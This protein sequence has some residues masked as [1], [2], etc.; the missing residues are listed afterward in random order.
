MTS[1]RVA[2]TPWG[3]GAIAGLSGVPRAAA[4]AP[5]AEAEDAEGVAGA[6]FAV[7]SSPRGSKASLAFA[8]FA[9]FAGS[10]GLA[11]LADLACSPSGR[12]WMRSL[13][14]SAV[15]ECS[16]S[17][18]VAITSR[19]MGRL[20]SSLFWI[21]REETSPSA[22]DRSA[23]PA[24]GTALGSSTITRPSALR[25]LVQTSGALASR[26]MKTSGAPSRRSRERISAAVWDARV[27]AAAG[28]GACLGAGAA[29]TTRAGRSV[30]EA[31]QPPT[32]TVRTTAEAIQRR[33][34]AHCFVLPTSPMATRLPYGPGNTQ[35]TR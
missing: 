7:A 11:G 30:L 33:N 18:R 29:S 15:T 16:T 3:A 31:V 14:P 19:V 25:K 12:S 1:S 28:F 21:A 9:G 22:G 4:P 8:G 24:R 35:L 23:R 13:A 34:P 2:A 6:G 20:P 27:S 10:A 17:W 26:S 5:V 32:A